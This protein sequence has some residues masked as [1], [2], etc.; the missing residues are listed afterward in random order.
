[1]M[2][3]LLMADDVVAQNC[4]PGLSFY[5]GYDDGGWP[6]A[7]AL[8][9]RFPNAF[10]VRA[11]TNPADDEGDLADCESGDM[12]PA[13]LVA[14]VIRRRASGHP[15][16]LGYCG[17]GNLSLVKQ[18]FASLHQPECPYIIANWQNQYITGPP[19]TAIPEAWLAM[20]VVGWQFVSHPEYDLS[21]VV[22]NLARIIG[23]QMLTDQ[24]LANITTI[25]QQ[26]VAAQV[27]TIVTDVL[28]NDES[29][30]NNQYMP[31]LKAIAT[32]LGVN[33]LPA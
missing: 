1:M 2:G 14:W 7:A 33:P 6:D 13:E 12:D 10:V 27:P 24:D 18:I 8:A 30:Y 21:L 11:T 31:W 15:N 32:K 20:G 25:V 9:A 19:P 29:L 4:P 16:P 22:S 5:L 26:Q 23:G 17:M 3:F 28:K